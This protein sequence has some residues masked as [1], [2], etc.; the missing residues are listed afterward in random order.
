MEPTI[1]DMQHQFTQHEKEQFLALLRTGTD[2]TEAAQ[3]VGADY[4]ASMFRRITNEG[5]PLYDAKFAADYVRARAEGRQKRAPD[6]APRAE[7]RTTTLSGHLKAKYITEEMLE[8][9]IDDIANGVRMKHAADRLEPKTSLSQI[10]KRALRDPSFADAYAT[11]KEQGYPIFRENLRAEA[12]RLAF[13]GD[14][15]ALRD[16]LLIHD[17]EF[18]EVLLTSKHEIGGPGG[19]ALRTLV[20]KALPD[21][22]DEIMEQMIQGIEERRAIER[23]KHDDEDDEDATGGVREP[24]RPVRPAGGIGDTVN[25]EPA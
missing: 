9:F 6:Q 11:A 7:P 22:P 16:Q 2:P 24:R 14:Y 17:P 5:N 19:E 4:T 23:A 18:R 20:Q 15:K 21:L 12:V 13:A 3:L 8:Q 25:P 1:T 10:H